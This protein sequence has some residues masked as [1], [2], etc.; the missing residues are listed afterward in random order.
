MRCR[1]YTLVELLMVVG[2]VILLACLSMPAWQRGAGSAGV[3]VAASQMLSGLALT[4]RLALSSGRPHTLCLTRD[5]VRCDPGG[6]EWMVFGNDGGAARRDPAEPVLRRFALPQGVR[7]SAT[8]GYATYLP[9]P[10]AAA[11]LTFSFCHPGAPELRRAVIVS[12]T[13]RARIQRSADAGG[14]P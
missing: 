14:C 2:T 6:G 1:G 4:R 10:G 11:T 3:R 13:G 7:V 5:E 8:R 9:R 12:Q